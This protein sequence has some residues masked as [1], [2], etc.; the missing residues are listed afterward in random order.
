M[1][2]LPDGTHLLHIGPQKTG[3]TAIQGALH[4]AREAIREHGVVYPGPDAKPRDAAEVGLGFSRIR[5]RGSDDAYDDLLRQVH[6]PT[7]RVACV[8]L[9]AF[10]RADDEQAARVVEAL[11]GERPHVLMVARRYDGLLPS[12]WQQR[13][14]SRLRLSYDEW[15]RVVLGDPDPDESLW[16]NLWVPHDT[17]AVV[18]RW[19]ALVGHDNVTVVVADGTRDQLHRAFE[20]LLG[21][22]DGIL[23]REAGQANSSLSLDRTELVRALNEEFHR[24]GWK[25]TKKF[26]QHE[27]MRLGAVRALVNLPPDP[28]APRNPP[29]PDWAWPRLVELSDRRVEGLAASRARIVGDLE[30][31]RVTPSAGDPAA[32]DTDPAD[33]RIDVA[34]TAMAAVIRQA[35]RGERKRRRGKKKDQ[36][37]D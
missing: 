3:S 31:L 9:E 20:D 15:L 35:T 33:V 32:R 10:G 8:S 14:K 19:G 7:A 13:V 1:D 36:A 34:A 29:L 37:P 30:L 17:L 2:A 24:R 11:G 18:D 22:P 25:A 23:P 28:S 12:Q 5:P 21:L 16:S 6:D 26:E 27:L 4:E